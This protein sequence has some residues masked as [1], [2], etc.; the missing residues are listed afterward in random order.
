VRDLYR[1]VRFLRGLPQYVLYSV[2]YCVLDHPHS[3]SWQNL[4]MLCWSQRASEHPVF[5]GSHARL[6]QDTCHRLIPTHASPQPPQPPI[7]TAG[8]YKGILAKRIQ[9][10]L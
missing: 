8:Q 6:C 4:R 7:R 9:L 5:G 2:D 3:N 10:R 1:T